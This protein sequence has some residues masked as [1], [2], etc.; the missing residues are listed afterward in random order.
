MSQFLL[1]PVSVYFARV[2]VS[3]EPPA[4]EDYSPDLSNMLSCYM[5]P[6]QSKATSLPDDGAIAMLRCR[7]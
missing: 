7:Q 6:Q 5:N 3:P 4:S 2:M 1:S